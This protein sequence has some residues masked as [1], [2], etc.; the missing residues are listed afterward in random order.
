[1][2]RIAVYAGSF[3][4]PTNGHIDIIRRASLI[5]DEIIVSVMIN[6]NK[7]FTFSVEERK[8]MLE[9]ATRSIKKVKVECFSG[10]LV[11]YMKKK[12][13]NIVIRGLR[14]VSDF[15]YEFQMTL[16][17]RRLNPSV[18]TIFL[19][20]SEDYRYLSSSVVKELEQLGGEIKG[21]VPSIVEKRLKELYG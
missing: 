15:D 1:M 18:E 12:K 21:L 14:A 2:K 17:N 16:M 5:F 20:P 13:T 9:Y 7:K 19:M 6:Q 11:D 10:L 3:D 4:P 8:K